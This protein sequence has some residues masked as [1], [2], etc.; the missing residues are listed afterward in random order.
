M[1]DGG[2]FESHEDGEGVE[3]AGG[4]E[5]FGEYE[6]C[7]VVAKDVEAV[8]DLYESEGIVEISACVFDVGLSD[9]VGVVVAKSVSCAIAPGGGFVVE[10]GVVGVDRGVVVENGHFGV[11]G[12]GGFIGEAVG[13]FVVACVCQVRRECGEV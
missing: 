2:I 3:F 13:L 7:A 1:C 10:F 11:C 9:I 4:E 5:V 8:G 12:Q 6:V